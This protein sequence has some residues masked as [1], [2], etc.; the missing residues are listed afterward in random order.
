MCGIFGITTQKNS[1][2]TQGLYKRLLD[3]LF[4]FSESRG[5]EASGF[6]SILDN[7][8]IVHKT[9]F[10]AKELIK[11]KIYSRHFGE[12][13]DQKRNN[14]TT[15]GHSR[16]VTNGY[17]HFNNN[18]QP[19]IKKNIVG[20]HNGIV[21]NIDQLW[22][23]FSDEKRESELDSEIIPTLLGRYLNQRLT[24]QNAIVSLYQ[25]IYG[26][27]SIAL[28]FQDYENLLLATNNGSLYFI[29][30]AD[31]TSII[32]ASEQYII[33]QIIKK[34]RLGRQFLISKIKQILPNSAYLIDLEKS[35]LS[36]LNFSLKPGEWEFSN[37]NPKMTPLI[38]KTID[39]KI[40]KQKLYINKSLE[41]NDFK[42]PA[43]FVETYLRRKHSI[44]KLIRCTRCLL[45]ETF[46]FI[47][48]DNDG[49]CNYCRNYHKIEYQGLEVFRNSIKRFRKTNG[50]PDCLM[51]F[52]GGRDSSYALHF[53]VTELG[54]KPIAYSY[55]WGMLTDLARRNQARMCGKL[56]IEHILISA[57]IRKKRS[58]IQKNVRAWLKRPHLGTIPLFM[59]GDK[60]YFYY[61]NL[62]MQQNDLKLSILGENMLETTNFKSGFC[63]IYPNH[64]KG[65]T[66]TL[67]LLNKLKMF[68]F[69]GKEYLLNPSY[70]NS[71]LLD[72]FDAFRSYYLIKHKNVNI[73]N[74][75]EWDEETIVKTLLNEYDWET[76]PGTKATWRIGD[77]TAAFYNYIYYMVAGFSEN[78]SFRSNQIRE[79]FFTRSD[80]LLKVNDENYPRYDSLKWYLDTIGLDFEAT[81]NIINQIPNLYESF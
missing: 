63:G 4:I 78:D 11:T 31:N 10:P 57:D 50:K 73:Y 64:A 49:V 8:I 74:Y 41:H 14:Y 60:Q 54:L 70:L 26:M 6:A 32:F 18:N 21:V 39:E 12:Y 69:Y 19:V 46:P 5:K 35:T 81:I 55:D 27:S 75:I 36:N 71:S 76:D 62:L 25:E 23:K 66:Y 44:E 24:L 42:T 80:A 22:H 33:K 1:S 45:P 56:G 58:N 3:D 16:L 13:F 67:S 53:V 17:E 29:Q 40:N 28:L 79:G 72:T 15:I 43:K 34:N 47:Q 59:A 7:K 20:I 68:S 65:H 38:I 9:P 51:P 37:I 77:G 30:S 48:F 52:S 2:I 61:A